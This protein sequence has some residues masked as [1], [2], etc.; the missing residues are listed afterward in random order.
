MKDIIIVD[1]KKFENL[2]KR[3]REEGPD[4][5]HVLA[6]FDRTLTEAFV[7]EE[8]ASTVI[9]QIRNGKYLTENYPK[10]AQNLFDH[11][12]PIEKDN[13]ISKEVKNKLMHEW[14]RKHFDLLVASGMN[15]EVMK[16]IISKK[17]LVLRDGVL[18]FLDDLNSLSIPLVIMSAGPGD[19]IIEHLKDEGKLYDVEQTSAFKP[20]FESEGLGDNIHIIANLFKFNNK[21]IAIGIEE[22]IIHSMNKHEIE[23]KDSTFYKKLLKRKM[24]FY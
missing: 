6:D 8:R 7:N 20:R 10:D 14:W 3:F 1:E 17:N 22:P 24:L 4:K 15:K 23:I 21:G 9:A 16:D 2:K 19:M 13:N 12:H 18:N 5:I 11:Y